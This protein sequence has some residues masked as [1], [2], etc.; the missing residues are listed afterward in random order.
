MF[1]RSRPV[2][3]EPHG[4]RRRAG[5]PRWLVLLL[6]GIAVGA[7]AVVVVQERYLP[8]RLSAEAGAQLRAAFE[9]ASTER[10]TLRRELDQ[11]G[12]RLAS[13]LA[14]RQRQAGELATSRAAAAGLQDDLAA[15]VD[16]LPA[17]PRGGAVQVRAARFTTARD[18]S[19]YWSGLAWAS[20][21]LTIQTRLAQHL[22]LDVTLQLPIALLRRD[23]RF[24][25][26]VLPAVWVGLSRGF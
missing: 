1:G 4:R 7:A 18:G 17:D 24:V 10:A 14:E 21:T 12:Q 11:T 16:A 5:P 8:P 3:F 23:D 19:L 6:V 22:G 2:F 15:A 20:P 13:A 9:Q 26:S 25:T